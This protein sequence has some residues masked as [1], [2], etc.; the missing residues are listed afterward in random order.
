MTGTMPDTK[1]GTMM[2]SM[3]VRIHAWSVMAVALMAITVAA[4]TLR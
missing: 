1:W 2:I 3:F 4:S